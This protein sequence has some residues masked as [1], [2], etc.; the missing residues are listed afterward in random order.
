MTSPTG[1][2]I[3]AI[4]WDYDGTLVDSREKN[5]NVTRKIVERVA[6]LESARFPA[7]QT[8]ESY[9][10]NNRAM[11]NWRDLYTKTFGLT[12]EQTDEAGKLWSEYQLNDATPTA[13]FE[14]MRDTLVALQHFFHGIVSQNSHG[15]I[16]RVLSAN[17][18]DHIFRSIIGYEEV[19]LRRQK[20]D[21][22]GLL[23]CIEALTQWKHGDVL[24][25]GDH[26]TDMECV[27]NTNRVLKEQEREIRVIS[28]GVSYSSERD[29]PGWNSKPDYEAKTVADLITIVKSL[30]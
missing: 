26:E 6:G 19:D 29:F 9:M 18:L 3:N 12:E 16:S 13:L 24:Y 17:Q 20:P 7:L 27:V 25:V 15:A 30:S 22:T 11:R 21:P 14:G 10:Q 1:N 28:V 23:I 8:V 2:T 4:V 5:L